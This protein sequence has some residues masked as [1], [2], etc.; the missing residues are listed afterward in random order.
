MNPLHTLPPAINLANCKNLFDMVYRLCVHDPRTTYKLNNW[1]VTLVNLATY[2]KID[3][4]TLANKLDALIGFLDSN[5][6]E[7]FDQINVET[8][9]FESH[10]NDLIEVIVNYGKPIGL[11][12]AWFIYASE[13]ATVSRTKDEAARRRY[14]AI[15]QEN[16][17]M[18]EA[19]R[20]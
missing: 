17:A 5:N 10:T 12:W 1:W 6:T 19:A 4:K 16:S 8:L 15:A 9:L 13:M 3:E 20:K 18:I 7:N 2:H 11:A 14:Y